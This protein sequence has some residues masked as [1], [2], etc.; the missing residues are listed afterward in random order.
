MFGA[1]RWQSP[2]N[3]TSSTAMPP[4]FDMDQGAESIPLRVSD[5]VIGAK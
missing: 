2:A 5:C 4:G 1:R 3:V